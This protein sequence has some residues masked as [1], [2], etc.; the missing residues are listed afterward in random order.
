MIQRKQSIFLALIVLVFILLLFMPIYEIKV[1][2][3]IDGQLSG[4]LLFIPLLLIPTACIS[5]LALFT[6]FNYKNRPRQIVLC[7]IGL[8]LSLLISV[9]AIV[10]PQFFIHGMIR[11]N[12]QVGNGAYLFPVNIVL[13]AFAAYFIKKDEDLVKAADRLR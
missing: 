13:F 10:F 11:D 3:N 7:R 2:S 9:N 8:I 1:T 4:K 5:L 6:I 12:L